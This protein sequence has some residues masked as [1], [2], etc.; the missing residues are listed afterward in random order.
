MAVDV[1]KGLG[2][3]NW[4]AVGLLAI[5]NVLERFDTVSA[6]D[7][8]CID[9]LKAMLK[10]ELAGNGE[11]DCVGVTEQDT[12]E[13]SKDTEREIEESCETGLQGSG[14]DTIH[15]S[16]QE[17][18]NRVNEQE[19]PEIPLR[20]SL[21]L[22]RFLK[23][24]IPTVFG[25]Q[26]PSFYIELKMFVKEIQRSS[27]EF[28]RTRATN[29]FTKLIGNGGSGIVYYVR[30]LLGGRPVAVKIL[31]G[32]SRQGKT[33][34]K[35][36]LRILTKLHHRNIMELVGY[37]FEQDMMLVYEYIP[38][39]LSNNNVTESSN[40]V[41]AE[42]CGTPG[43][44]DPEYLR[45]GRARVKT[46]IY[47]FG[48]TLLNI[49]SGKRAVEHTDGLSLPQHAWKLSEEDRLRELIDPRLLNTDNSS[50][51]TRAFLTA[52]WCIHEESKR[53]PSASRVLIMLL[54]GEEIPI[55]TRSLEPC[56][57]LGQGHVIILSDD[58]LARE[59][60]EPWLYLEFNDL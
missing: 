5:A 41:T 12:S 37:C 20:S 42:V 59:N 11:N 35:N 1:L 39:N 48:V 3:V 33:K 52:L 36:E 7:R 58:S 40:H 30:I 10:L 29:G 2:N 13:Q 17:S 34:W 57:E 32:G 23:K 27:I 53:R 4:V 24:K 49:V 47:S 26:K 21:G 50:S 25:H 56:R 15:S 19:Q 51:I 6:N 31:S 54:S 38:R 16:G 8:E 9:L 43:Y 45:I 14:S 60:L 18:Y 55:P 44:V 22:R 28:N 46:D